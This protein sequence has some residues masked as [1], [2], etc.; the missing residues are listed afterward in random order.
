MV[1]FASI[2]LDELASNELDW[3]AGLRV[4]AHQSIV[5]LSKGDVEKALE[6]ADKALRC[7]SQITFDKNSDVLR[8]AGALNKFISTKNPAA[9]QNITP[10]LGSDYA[11]LFKH[12]KNIFVEA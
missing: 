9:M 12:D 10:I 7:V 8:Y 3:Y 6:Y 5:Q 1:G 4:Y 2:L 11:P